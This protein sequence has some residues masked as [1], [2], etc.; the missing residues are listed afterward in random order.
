MNNTRKREI[1]GTR[2]SLA[3]FYTSFPTY[4]ADDLWML[5]KD[6][7]YWMLLRDMGTD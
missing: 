6:E 4:A 5:E 2:S 3:S 1:E 7:A